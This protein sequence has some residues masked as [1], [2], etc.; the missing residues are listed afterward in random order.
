MHLMGDFGG[1][2]KDSPAEH[3]ECGVQQSTGLAEVVQSKLNREGDRKLRL[4]HDLDC[5]ARVDAADPKSY[6]RGLLS[7]D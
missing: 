2:E 7:G 3:A 4:G 1:I 6:H 5:T